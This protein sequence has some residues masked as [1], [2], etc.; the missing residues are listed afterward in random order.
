LAREFTY[1]AI[2]SVSE[3]EVEVKNGLE[4]EGSSS[5]NQGIT[6]ARRAGV[7][8]T[9]ED[10]ETLARVFVDHKGDLRPGLSVFMEARAVG[11]IGYPDIDGRGAGI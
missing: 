6:V 8:V 4:K 9:H 5:I 11:E 1:T 10:D 2:K 3:S 7:E